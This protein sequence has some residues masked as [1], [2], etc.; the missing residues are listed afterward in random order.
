MVICDEAHYLM[1]PQ[2]YSWLP[3]ITADK[4][5]FYTATPIS[6][7][8]EGADMDYTMFGDVI[9]RVAPRELIRE[10]YIVAPLVHQ[11]ECDTLKNSQGDDVD[12]LDIIAHSYVYQFNEVAKNGMSYH[13]M[14]VAARGV[15]TDL[16]RI[17]DNIN[18]IWNK[19]RT[20]SNGAIINPDIYTVDAGATIVNGVRTMDRAS[21]IEEITESQSNAIICHYDTL[22]EGI[23]I[24][25][26]G[27][28]VIM[29]VMNKAKFIQTIGR[30]ARPNIKDLL[31]DRT[32]NPRLFDMDRGI[33]CRIKP[34]CIV[35]LP[36]INGHWI[37]NSNG[38]DLARAF[39]IAGYDDLS[40]YMPETE[41]RGNG[42]K[43]DADDW[44]NDDD[45]S[46]LQQS[47]SNVSIHRKFADL[48]ELFEF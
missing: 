25:S 36:V 14:L 11:L 41:D 32:P 26:L 3:K 21:A 16:H 30:T 37:A 39:I 5:L 19:I 12:V 8:M 20:I 1:Q 7:D 31:K 29:R 38:E 42:G 18:V 22:S 47:I 45:D 9:A 15:S 4:I 17:R 27:G 13:Q 23:D 33:D 34:R 2:F 6:R 43:K 44:F 10:G 35:T 28:S 46:G 48:R 40:T 24:D